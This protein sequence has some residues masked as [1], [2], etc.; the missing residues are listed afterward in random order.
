MN[1]LL[2]I[3]LPF[4]LALALACGVRLAL[5]P[6]RG[7]RMA[8]VAAVVAFLV[9]WGIVLRP[10]WFAFTP[11][12]RIGHVAVGAALT[13]LVLDFFA[14]RRWCAYVAMGVVVLVSCW[15][16]LNQGLWPPHAFT[17]MKGAALVA[18]AAGAFLVLVRIDILVPR[19]LTAPITLAML[20]FGLAAVA[21]VARDGAMV[22]TALALAMAVAGYMAATVLVP[23]GP[24]R[25]LALGAGATMLAIAWAFVDRNPQAA[26]GLIVLPLTLFAEG[27]ARRVPLPKAGISRILYPLV[28][29]AVSALPVIIAILITLAIRT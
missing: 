20:C 2:L 10:G 15:A 12:G 4:G 9:T 26:L 7:A 29:A 18:L 6:E 19:D 25:G 17:W 27:T 14:V 28:L 22:A 23:L 5:G 1:T 13:A 24:S 21:A 8:G 16:S 11:V 3:F